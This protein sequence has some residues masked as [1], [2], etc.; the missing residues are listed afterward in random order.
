MIPNLE[1]GT[2]S[3][4]YMSGRYFS[5]VQDREYSET[6][7]HKT[8]SHNPNK[9][10]KLVRYQSISSLKKTLMPTKEDTWTKAELEQQAL[11]WETD[12]KRQLKRKDLISLWPPYK[13]T[14]K[15]YDKRTKDY[16]HII[17]KHKWVTRKGKPFKYLQFKEYKLTKKEKLHLRLLQQKKCP[18]CN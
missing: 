17:K 1:F 9:L 18:S 16:W 6:Y 12:L 11:V 10:S 3:D 14:G 4:T 15:Q 8:A 5:I 13:E 7:I 2:L